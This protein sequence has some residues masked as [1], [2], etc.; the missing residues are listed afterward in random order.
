V[1]CQIQHRATAVAIYD[2]IEATVARLLLGW[3][4]VRLVEQVFENGWKAS[5]RIDIYGLLRNTRLAPG[6]P[7]QSELTSGAMWVAG[8]TDQDSRSAGQDPELR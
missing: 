4:D 7:K 6:A 1:G 3:A 2:R 8:Q 5:Q